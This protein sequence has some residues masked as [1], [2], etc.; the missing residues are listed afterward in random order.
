MWTTVLFFALLFTSAEAQVTFLSGEQT[1]GTVTAISSKTITLHSGQED[2]DH[3]I[4][5]MQA[6]V[7]PANLRM[8]PKA[9]TTSI[10]F[11]DGTKLNAT[12]VTLTDSQIQIVLGDEHKLDVQADSI[13]DIRFKTLSGEALQQYEAIIGNDAA[14][15]I[16]IIQRDSGA[17]DQLE[18]IV[19]SLD[20]EF[21][22]FNFGGDKIPV[23]IKKLAGLRLLKPADK[24]LSV[25]MCKITDTQ[26]NVFLASDL[27]FNPSDRMMN[28]KLGTG[29]SVNLELDMVHRMDFSSNNVLYLS[30]LTPESVE[31]K[32]FL[33]GNL[34]RE[35]LARVYRPRLDTSLDGSPIAIGGE[36]YRK[37]FSLH[38]RTVMALRLPEAYSKLQMDIGMD[39]AMNG[40]GHVEL[41]ILGDN[42]Q[43]FHDFVSGTDAPRSL[44]IN[45]TG[46]R[47]I[48][49]TVDYGKNLD[50]GD[51]LNLGN[52]R[53]LK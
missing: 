15:D 4:D 6:V 27:S 20:D 36:S 14:E 10:T 23:E 41:I 29:D 53:V 32:P 24:K 1:T 40:R 34:I 19:E 7:F 42:K 28:I 43:L 39:P 22:N 49:I 26:N 2:T 12:K 25:T 30:D 17:L 52:A 45:I 13:R 21:V 16:L 33:T 9:G 48:T 35:R 31:W 8:P 5:K 51:Q 3:S 44:D 47:R 38:S 37:G 46:I 50:I 11:Y 18:G